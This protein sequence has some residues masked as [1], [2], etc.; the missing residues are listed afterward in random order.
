[1]RP[2]RLRYGFGYGGVWRFAVLAVVSLVIGSVVLTISHSVHSIKIPSFTFNTGGVTTGGGGTD[3]PAQ[4]QVTP[5]PV[6]YLTPHG[7]RA[8][9]A[10][11]AHIAHGGK[12]TLLR[13]DARTLNVYATRPDGRTSQIYLGP[14]V[15][16]VTPAAAPGERPLPAS[17]IRPA[18]LGSLLAQ[19]HRRFGVPAS[20]IDYVV[21]SSPSG[22]PPRWV[23]FVRDA[24]HQGY[25]APLGGGAWTR[26]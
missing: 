23:L 2:A 10:R 18:V 26:I 22:Q 11:V 16:F 9:L 15:T 12:L 25:V 17:S 8:G 13:I 4:P 3:A 24:A 5:R 14:T 7:L 20:R 21:V 19:L 1:M 6:H